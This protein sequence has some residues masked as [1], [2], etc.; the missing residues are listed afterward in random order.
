MPRRR[1]NSLYV[2]SDSVENP[3]NFVAAKRL[4]SNSFFVDKRL[5]ES[6]DVDDFGNELREKWMK[7]N[8]N[9]RLSLGYSPAKKGNKT[10]KNGFKAI[11]WN[12]L[13]NV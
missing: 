12:D 4:R 5:M 8:R 7:I 6:A 1:L 13:K 11:K 3:E 9:R 10:S 2:C